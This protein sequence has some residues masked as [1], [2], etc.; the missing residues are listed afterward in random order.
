MDRVVPVLS[1]VAL[2]TALVASPTGAHAQQPLREFLAARG[3]GSLDVREARAALRQAQSQV[4]EARARLLPSFTAQG[5]YQRN[6]FEAGFTNPV[7]GGQVV[8]QPFDSLTAQFTATVPL[9]DIGSWS[10]FFQTEAIA[11]SQSARLELADQN[12]AVAIVQIWHQL[13]GSR[14][15]VEASERNL[16]ALERNREAAAARVEVGVAAQL[17][18][19]R[20]E[21][22]VTRAQQSL[23]EA[24]LAVVLA[25]RNLENLTGLTP[26]DERPSLEEVP[27]HLEPFDAYMANSSDLPAVR[28]AR[29][30]SRAADIAADTAWTSLL[31]IISGYARESGSN[32]AGFQGANWSYALGVQAV[33]TLDFL[34]PAQIGTRQAAA[35]VTEVQLE[36]AVQQTETSIFDAYQ[37]VGA[38]RARTDAATAGV[39]S[40]QRAAEDARVRFEAGAATQLDLI[41]AERD[42]FQAEVLRIQAL[43]DLHVAHATLRI[44]AGMEL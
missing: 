1:L 28:A 11:D 20:A 29:A 38:A 6:E 35:E 36:R 42:L 27:P 17:E 32:A 26:I 7:T 3:T 43:A 12:V 31:P 34:R 8:I 30:A 15:V 22:E 33:W 14:A 18:L 23:A 40:A 44:R 21:T 19:S 39:A 4:D 5:G 2:V 9:I 16:E 41:Q 13:V 24:R 37:R 25:A 10:V